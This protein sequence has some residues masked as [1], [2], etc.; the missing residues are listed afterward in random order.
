MLVYYLQM[1]ET[2]E[3]RDKF[4]E[5][6]LT[7]RDMMHA[8]AFGVLGNR[9]DAEDAV[10]NA[11]L[12]IINNMDKFSSPSDSRTK[13]YFARITQTVSID[14]LR[15]RDKHPAVKLNEAINYIPVAD[16]SE[17]AKL[18]RAIQRI[19]AQ[20]Q[21][22]LMYYADAKLDTRDIAKILGITRGNAQKRI[23]RAKE[24][25]RQ[26]YEKEEDDV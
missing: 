20:Y 1:I 21:E 19:P 24:A 6:Y 26:E 8:I 12:V 11:F 4:T 22:V 3:A 13:A 5:A 15:K 18:Q 2:V 10:H 25:L 17:N 23:W 9:Y 14:F 16:D 7:Y